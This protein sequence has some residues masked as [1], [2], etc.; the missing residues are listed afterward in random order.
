MPGVLIFSEKDELALALASKGVEVAQGLKTE[1]SAVIL[2]PNGR[3]RAA[4]YFSKGVAKAY[5]S[6][7]ELLTEFD[8]KLYSQA[9]FQIAEVCQPEILLCVSTK[10]G[11]EVAPRLAQM[12]DAGCLTN[13]L[14][15]QVKDGQLTTSRYGL[16]GATVVSECLESPKKVIAVLPQSFETAQVKAING[17]VISVELKLDKPIVTVMERRKRA[18]EAVDI[19]KSNVLICVGKGLKRKEDLELIQELASIIKGEV[20]C[21]REISSNLGWLTEDRLVGM[22]G[23]RCKPKVVFSIGISGQN[24]YVAGISGAKVSVAINNDAN[25]PIFKAS[26]Y[27]LVDDLYRVLPKLIEK[28]R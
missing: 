23:K 19:E 21:T 9:I 13:V 10:R 6:E 3:S 7:S 18:R 27:G 17:Q 20:G 4:Q 22:S 12:L 5:I 28:L 11:R 1:L 15:I 25:A 16:G 14:D 24:Q 26:D 8:A 2:G